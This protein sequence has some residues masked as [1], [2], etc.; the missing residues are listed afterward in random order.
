MFL[1]AALT[2]SSEGVFVDVG[3][4]LEKL[5]AADDTIEVAPGDERTVAD[6]SFSPDAFNNLGQA[7]VFVA[8]TDG[9]EGLF[10][11][12]LDGAPEPEPEPVPEPSSIL[13]L[14]GGLFAMAFVT[15]RRRSRCS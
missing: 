12:G 5:L 2:G 1:F 9:S 4:G 8:F 6:I 13:I 7:L 15:R 14:S 3:D 10:R 11:V